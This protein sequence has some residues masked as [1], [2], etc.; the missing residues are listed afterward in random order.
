MA[1][2]LYR[3]FLVENN[4]SYNFPSN[5]TLKD[6]IIATY[7]AL[8]DTLLRSLISKVLD[9]KK[10]KTSNYQTDLSGWEEIMDTIKSVGLQI[11]ETATRNLQTIMSHNNDETPQNLIR[12]IK[13]I[14][15]K[16]EI[17]KTFKDML[18]ASK[19]ACVREGHED[20]AS[21][22]QFA[23]EVITRL[24]G[25]ATPSS[26]PAEST[27]PQTKAIK[28]DM[29]NAAQSQPSKLSIPDPALDPA[30]L[31][32]SGLLLRELVQTCAGDAVNLK[33]LLISHL[34]TNR[35][36]IPSF[37]RVLVDN[38]E[39][40]ER[41]NYPNKVKL[42]DFINQLIFTHIASLD[43]SS[44][45][46]NDLLSSTAHTPQF[47]DNQQSSTI[48]R[49]GTVNC[50]ISFIDATDLLTNLM[51]TNIKNMKKKADKRIAK[52]TANNIINHIS[53]HIQ[54]NAW[55]VV[56]N[57]LPSDLVKRVR[58]EANLFTEFYEQSEIWVC[59]YVYMLVCVCYI[60]IDIL[61]HI[62][63]MRCISMLYSNVVFVSCRWARKL[64]L[65]PKYLYL[66]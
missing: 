40:A 21:V 44:T 14:Y 59:V 19:E 56:D 42:Y 23:C 35:I 25:K 34:T 54:S 55:V 4:I 32:A 10:S 50:P 15:D 6:V 9:I 2:N 58:I 41:A 45:S 11:R 16:Q 66:L 43:A 39:A 49:S 30:A 24:E 46:D 57:Y 63:M 29:T 28:S 53:S 7:D 27:I 47:V 31:E 5:S 3:D 52:N 18:L 8:H 48:Q 26:L 33:E 22:Y 17:T 36:D 1:L 12:F 13:S 60:L 61:Y 65:V 37:Q 51:Q 20:S 62:S 38:K 64:M